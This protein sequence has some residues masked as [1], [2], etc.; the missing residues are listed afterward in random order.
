MTDEDWEH[1][2]MKELVPVII[3]IAKFSV[4][5]TLKIPSDNKKK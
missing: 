4:T 1:V 2:K 5:E 3:G